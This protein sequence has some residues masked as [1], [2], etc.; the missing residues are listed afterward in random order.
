[1]LASQ[2]EE[3]ETGRLRVLFIDQCHLLWG[4]LTGY[5]WGRSDQEITVSVVNERKKQTY[6]GAVDYLD[7]ELI[8]K[9]YDAGNSENTID[10]LRYL[11]SQ[12]AEQQLLILW[13]GAS[14]HRS[15]AVRAFLDEVNQGLPVEQWK[16]HC[17]RFAPNCP[18]QNPIEDIWLQAKTWVR[19]FCALIPTFSHLTWMF[20]WFIQNTTFDFATFQMYGTFSKIK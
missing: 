8:L 9:A 11:L 17:V 6:Y 16:I 4:D 12:S 10:Y 3:I 19:R 18:Q 7:R 20:E 13:D 2:R 14:Y 1:M 5:V 15:E